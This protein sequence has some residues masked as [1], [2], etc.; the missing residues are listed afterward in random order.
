MLAGMA[1]DM[2]WEGGATAREVI[3]SSR[4]RMTR[5]QYLTSQRGIAKRELFDGAR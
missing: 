1:I 5:E 3:A 2:L 4:P